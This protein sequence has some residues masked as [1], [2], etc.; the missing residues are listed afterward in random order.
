MDVLTALVRLGGTATAQE[1]GRVVRRRELA[2]AVEAG[3][4]VRIGWGKYAVPGVDAAEVAR[5]R[6]SGV[7]SHLSAAMAWGWKVRR[8]PARP[9][10]TVARHRG[11]VARSG[12]ELRYADLAPDDVVDGRTSRIRTVLDCA[13]SLSFEDALCVADQAVREGVVQRDQLVAA[14]YAG[15][16]THR[17]KAVRVVQAADP[18]AENPFES[19]LRAIALEVPALRVQA[20]CPVSCSLGTVHADVGDPRQRIAAEA[21]S[22]EFHGLPEAFAYDIRRYT[23]MVRS[24]W[25]VVRFTWD[26]VMHKPGY[27]RSV[28][29]DLVRVRSAAA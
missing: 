9:T 15:P 24:G 28:L 5:R 20:Q 26:D 23:A 14:A 25:L 27:V 11:R 22:W 4:V 12:I 16:R 6:T 8:P 10:V 29:E 13:R 2:H 7:I 17:A 3:E 19:C 1:L 18:A 21:E